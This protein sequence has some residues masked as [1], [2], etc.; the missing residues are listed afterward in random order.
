MKKTKIIL[1]VLGLVGL[2]LLNI[3]DKTTA[4][5]GKLDLL[6][7][8]SV[9]QDENILINEWSLYAR[10]KMVNLQD[11]K[12]IKS[13][14]EE[15]KQQF[16]DWEWATNSDKVHSESVGV[17]KQGSETESIKILST[18]TNG[19]FQTYV[20]YEVKGQVW[21]KKVEESI[22]HKMA[23]RISDIF[24]GNATIFSC[25]KGEFNDKMIKTLP[26]EMEH[27][28]TIFQAEEIEALKED[29]FIS[30]TA[31]S[32]MFSETVEVGEK[33]MNV[34]IGIRNPGMGGKTTLVVGTP[35]I[36]IEY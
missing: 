9:L 20:I 11:Q 15:L 35:I 32:T 17:L 27:L 22:P 3:G 1:T 12:E 25:I 4:A 2:I 34:Q 10:E 30:S 36:T 26:L 13:Y 7:M 24:R 6:K 19:Q 23:S 29:T 18:S 8:A 31:H 33:N 14:T 28:L 5:D 16:P 21:D